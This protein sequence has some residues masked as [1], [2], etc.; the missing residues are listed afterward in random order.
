MMMAG[1]GGGIDP[2]EM[3]QKMMSGG[4]LDTSQS[5]VNLQSTRNNEIIEMEAPPGMLP[6][7]GMIEQIM[8]VPEGNLPAGGMMGMMMSVAQ[9]A[10]R[11]GG[12]MPGG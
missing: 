10:N 1:S 5:G 6:P 8:S 9:G 11:M 3:M 7:P 12:M 2:R 4:P